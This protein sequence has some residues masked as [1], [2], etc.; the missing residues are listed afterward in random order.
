[1]E[2]NSN[3]K[4]KIVG[5][6]TLFFLVGAAIGYGGTTCKCSFLQAKPVLG[7]GIPNVLRRFRREVRQIA[8]CRVDMR[9]V[10]ITVARPLSALT[11][12]Y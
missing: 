5:L 12:R 10:L 4:S 3:N 1:M 6:V 8:R 2:N 9:C 11:V 7:W